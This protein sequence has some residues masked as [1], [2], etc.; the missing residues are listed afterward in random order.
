MFASL[1]FHRA[2]AAFPVACI[3]Y[4]L[5]SGPVLLWLAWREYSAPFVGVFVAAVISDI[6]DGMVARRIGQVT[7][8]LRE[9]DSRADLLLYLCIVGAI[10]QVY[11]EVLRQFWLPL[12]LAIAAQSLQWATSLLKYGRLASYHSYSA[13]IWGL[14]LAVATV[15]LFGFGYAGEPFFVALIIG[16]LH[17]L[18]EVAMTC[19]L[20]QW[21]FDVKTIR[22]AW[23]IGRNA[24]IG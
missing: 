8:R 13:K 3:L 19:I 21:T 1:T 24:A 4:R 16:I 11:P 17:N 18:E 9:A 23:E 2:I 12:S 10:W 14:S 5:S 6:V 7:A 15:S 22:E 20:P